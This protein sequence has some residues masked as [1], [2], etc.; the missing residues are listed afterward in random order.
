MSKAGL[1]VPQ[2]T[3]LKAD[4]GKPRMDLLPTQ[5]LLEISRVLSFGAEKYDDHNWRGG[6]K[7]SRLIGAAYRHL[8]AFNDGEDYDPESGYLHLGHL[9]CCTMFLLEQKIKGTGH[10]DRYRV[11]I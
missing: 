4:G 11:S 1:I 7:Y 10:D 6:I 2:L 8:S 5:P 9:G 3:G